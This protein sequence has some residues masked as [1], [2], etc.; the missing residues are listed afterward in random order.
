M[1]RREFVKLMGSLSFTGLGAGTRGAMVD[2]QRV[3]RRPL[4]RLAWR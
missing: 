2:A 3:P 1:K 4:A